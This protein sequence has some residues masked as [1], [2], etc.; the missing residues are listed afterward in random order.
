MAV[1]RLE[2]HKKISTSRSVCQ[3]SRLDPWEP[4]CL[5]FPY[6]DLGPGPKMEF[7]PPARPHGDRAPISWGRAGSRGGRVSLVPGHV[8]T[9]PKFRDDRST[10]WPQATV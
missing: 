6:S 10:G 4:S 5:S 7:L 1:T 2:G 8:N 9:W 3:A